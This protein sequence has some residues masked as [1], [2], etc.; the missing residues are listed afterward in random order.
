MGII[1]RGLL[2]VG[3]IHAFSFSYLYL[4]QESGGRGK[5]LNVAVDEVL[6]TLNAGVLQFN[7]V[8]SVAVVAAEKSGEALE[9]SQQALEQSANALRGAN[10][11]SESITQIQE[12]H[13]RVVLGAQNVQQVANDIKVNIEETYNCI[14]KDFESLSKEQ[15][16]QNL[17]AAI[18]AE[19]AKIEEMEKL[20]VFDREAKIKARATIDAEEAKIKTL[21]KNLV[22][23]PKRISTV[24]LAISSTALIIYTIKNSLYLL[25]NH[26]T[27][28]RVITE[29]SSNWFK[30]QPEIGLKELI[31]S[32]DLKKQLLDLALRIK[33]AKSYKE[34]LPNILFY[35]APGTGK[36]AF[37]KALAYDSGLKY[38]F[39]SGSEFAKI[40]DLNIANN[41]LRELLSWAKNDSNGLIIFI[42]EAESLFA[43]RKLPETSKAAQDFINTFLALVP[44]KSHKKLM[45][46]FATNNP[47][48][49]DDAILDRIGPKIEFVLPQEEERQMILALYLQKFSDENKDAKVFIQSKVKENLPAYAKKLEGFSPRAIKFVAEEMIVNARHQ[50]YKWLTDCIAQ[51]V[52]SDAINNLQ[53]EALWKKDRDKLIAAA[54]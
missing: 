51:K 6:S 1:N 45:F 54:R 22:D 10:E 41:E 13:D 35:G 52:L 48:K 17:D 40:T 2:I 38:A 23:D 47:V 39:T 8:A 16:E 27:K 50:E 29:T 34:N 25:I 46:I 42:D 14:R 18:Q 24:V 20:G 12:L 53:Q 43:N 19:I 7:R 3:F 9:K 15:R 36:T 28:P 11:S 31:F 4:M 5:D 30:P 33:T 37:V 21:I 44:E 32:P 26:L 49:L